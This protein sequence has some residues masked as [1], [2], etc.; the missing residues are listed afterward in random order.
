LFPQQTQNR[1]GKVP[2]GSAKITHAVRAWA[3]GMP[4]LLD[5][6]GTPYDRER[7]YAYAFRH[8]YAQRLLTRAARRTC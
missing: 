1:S 8:S 4:E 3:R 6:D 2:L 5:S 7:V